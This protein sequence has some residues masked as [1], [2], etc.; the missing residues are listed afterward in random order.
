MNKQRAKTFLLISFICGCFLSAGTTGKLTGTIKSKV[1]DGPLIGANII[2]ENTDLGTSTDL[3]GDYVILNIAPGKYN[4]TIRMIGYEVKKYE[5]IRISIDKTTRLSSALDIEAVKGQEVVVSATRPLIDFDKTNSEAI[6]TSEELAIMPIEDVADVIKLQGGVT[7]DAGGGI[8]I[9]G[10]RSSEVAYLVDGVSVTDAYDGAIAVNIENA[11]IQE[12]Q[13]I[14][15]TF[16]AEYGKA[17]SGIVNIVT[18]DG[19]DKFESY[20]QVYSGDH[21]SDDNIYKNLNSYTLTNDKN[22][23]LSLSGPIIKRKLNFFISARSYV[24]DGWLNGLQTFTMYGDT[25][26][27]DNNLN[28]YF[29]STDVKKEPYYRA[30]NWRDKYSVQTK[31]TYKLNPKLVLRLNSIISNEQWQNYN[32]YSQIAQEGQKTNYAGGNFTGL[33]LSQ[34]FSSKTFYDIN[35]N[36]SVH[37]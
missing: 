7:Q 34:S 36:Q 15:G 5:N 29:D 11:N 25:V 21:Q 9:R 30:M 13:V 24:S 27:I 32:H 12:L 17:M 22:I 19:G 8:H 3:N 10:G 35:I 37:E 4:V 1:D 20:L 26:H 2:I 16:N 31:L 6:V 33:K 18:K 23:T 28:G 14:S